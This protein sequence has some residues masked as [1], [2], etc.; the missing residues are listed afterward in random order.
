MEEGRGEYCKE[1]EEGSG[2]G[3][4]LGRRNRGG[5]EGM[6]WVGKEN[7]RWEDRHDG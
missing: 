6:R 3:G 5:R 2:E 7:T 1:G 4:R